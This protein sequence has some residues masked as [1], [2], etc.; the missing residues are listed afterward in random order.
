MFQQDA[1]LRLI[2]ADVLASRKDLEAPME[3]VHQERGV[4]GEHCD[5]GLEAAALDRLCAHSAG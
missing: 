5:L 2:G 3:H 4:A 1:P